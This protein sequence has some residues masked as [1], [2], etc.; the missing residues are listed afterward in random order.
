M[1]EVKMAF[2]GVRQYLF[3]ES[4]LALTRNSLCEFRPPASLR[5]A[6]VR[7]RY[8]PRFAGEVIERRY[9]SREAGEVERREAAFG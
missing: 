6:S 4:E 8:G 7:C 3:F 5:F 1:W 2:Q 9:L